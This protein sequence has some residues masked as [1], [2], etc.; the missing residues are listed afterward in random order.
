MMKLKI[1]YDNVAKLPT[2][3]TLLVGKNV[4]KWFLIRS[5]ERVCIVQVVRYPST[6]LGLCSVAGNTV[7][8]Y[9][10]YEVVEHLTGTMTFDAPDTHTNRNILRD[11]IRRYREAQG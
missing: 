6:G 7:S 1:Q 5:D 4:G 3:D 8:R 9:K 10:R 2:A 11:A